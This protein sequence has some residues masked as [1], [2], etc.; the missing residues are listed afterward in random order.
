[1]D[2]E[3]KCNCK[4]LIINT[5]VLGFNLTRRY[6]VGNKMRN[7]ISFVSIVILVFFIQSCYTI[8]K[9]ENVDSDFHKTNSQ[10][11]QNSILNP[12]LVGVWINK[13]LWMDYGD[14]IRRLEIKNNGNII[15]IPNS[16]RSSSHIYFGSY[17]I[18]SD[19][20]IIKFNEKNNSEWMN[21]KLST[22]TLAIKNFL[23]GE[24]TNDNLINDCY[25]CITSWEKIQ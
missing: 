17:R 20:L 5:A 22:Y 7:H 15:Y 21:Y 18:Q 1:V 25:N 2:V 11:P 19:T 13:K 6:I 23:E 4:Y 12:E 16:E 9:K 10:F 3:I 8:I 14:Q 24:G